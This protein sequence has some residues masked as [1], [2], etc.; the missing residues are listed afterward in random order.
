M[1]TTAV[2]PARYASTRFPGK[3]LAKQ[4]GKYLIQH[5]CEQV[6]RCDAID[7]VVVATDD[8]RIAE[9]VTSFGGE[10]RMTREDHPSGTDRV[11]EVVD[12]IGL[13]D[14]DLVLNV[15]GDEPEI[16]PEA[17]T[18]LVGV[19]SSGS[20]AIATLAAPFDKDGPTEGPG[21]PLDP[22]CVK[23][24]AGDD[25]RALYFSR[26]L[27]PYPRT[28]HGR[29]ERPSDWLLHLG[30]YAFQ[31]DSLRRITTS[32]GRRADGLAQTE[33]LEQLAWL[34][35]GFDIGVATIQHPFVGIDT[36]EDYAAFVTRVATRGATSNVYS[37][38]E[39][40]LDCGESS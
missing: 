21:S 6:A 20:H 31:T 17:L 11:A 36:P 18:R 34:Q 5:V 12:A 32:A 33:S 13:Q 24:V 39:T 40:H 28:S 3:P 19:I 23:V 4:T 22:N 37:R 35:A 16:A 1:T 38:Q 8:R 15:Q 10:A 14:G 29:I 27:V 26:S 25:G 30:V 7:R 9:A 2:I